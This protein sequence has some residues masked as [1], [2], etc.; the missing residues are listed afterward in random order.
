MNNVPPD[1]RDELMSLSLISDELQHTKD[2]IQEISE[3]LNVQVVNLSLAI[4]TGF[5]C[6]EVIF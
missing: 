1:I 4:S 2:N 5:Q 6:N 3:R